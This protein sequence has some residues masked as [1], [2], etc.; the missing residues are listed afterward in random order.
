MYLRRY[1]KSALAQF[2]VE[3]VHAGPRN[4]KHICPRNL[5]GSICIDDVDA[6]PIAAAQPKHD[7]LSAVLPGI[8]QLR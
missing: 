1:H 4:L 8:T 2:C 3:G 7:A 6:I 5:F